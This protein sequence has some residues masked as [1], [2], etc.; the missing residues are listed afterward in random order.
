M[1]NFR[2][3][4][5]IAVIIAV[6]VFV[7][8]AFCAEPTDVLSARSAESIYVTARLSNLN[9]LM[10]AIF[11]RQNVDAFMTAFVKDVPEEFQLL[12]ALAAQIPAES[13]GVSV[14][15][16]SGDFFFQLAATLPSE[17]AQNVE[18]VSKGEAKPIDV[19]AVLLGQMGAMLGETLT[20][21]LQQ[22]D[23]GLPYYEV[24]GGKLVVAAKDGLV[25]LAA[26]P[27]DLNASTAALT[28][29]EPRLSVERRFGSGDYVFS[30]IDMPTY[31]AMLGTS[32]TEDMKT[33]SAQYKAPLE[34]EF[35]FE[36]KPESFLV[37]VS[38]NLPEAFVATQDFPVMEA[39]KGAD[40]FLAG[41]GNAL[42][43]LA[44]P[45]FFNSAYIKSIPSMA[46]NWRELEMFLE[47]AGI[48]ETDLDALLSGRISLVVGNEASVMGTQSVPGAYVALSGKDGAAAKILS[49]YTDN[50]IFKASFAPVLEKTAERNMLYTLSNAPVTALVGVNGETL[51]LGL[52]DAQTIN[53]IPNLTPKAQTVLDETYPA[54]GFINTEALWNR[55][56]NEIET[57]G[58]LT[59][60]YMGAYPE[61]AEAVK[62]LLD[63]DLTVNFVKFT[64]ESW[65]KGA[66]E[67]ALS[68]VPPEKALTPRL[69]NALVVLTAKPA[70][71][72]SDVSETPETAIEEGTAIKTE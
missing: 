51:F 40:V 55:L 18:L 3:N 14:G 8:R 34:W 36:R 33:L 17:Y 71:A 26:S 5:F 67:F 13:V 6:L 7:P 30:H 20:P 16:D 44:G 59:A 24:L 15:M 22:S 62:N 41:G 38:V 64:N 58:P 31:A 29:N 72:E 69:I 46:K 57:P 27:E 63:A 60:E 28:G 2:K 66:I 19:A 65:E 42:L 49:V 4:I 37:S 35:D 1:K 39:K 11:A 45:V 54:G 25:M 47:S 52:A 68:D 9:G 48:S 23:N 21:Q 53:D 32:E 70:P 56:R 43:A 50:E 10:K 12:A 61:K